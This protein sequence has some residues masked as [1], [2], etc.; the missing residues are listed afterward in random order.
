MKSHSDATALYYSF[1]EVVTADEKS[2]PKG[3]RDLKHRC[4][5]PGLYAQ[6]LDRWLNYFPPQQ[7][8]LFMSL[9]LLSNL[10]FF[11]ISFTVNDYRRRR[12]KVRSRCS[13]V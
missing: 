4:L 7:V 10:V 2:S 1:Q 11:T 6:H 8:C 13:S 9:I 3:L 5:N 12:T